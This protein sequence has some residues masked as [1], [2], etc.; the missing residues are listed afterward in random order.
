MGSRKQ[1]V[2]KIPYD[3]LLDGNAQSGYVFVT[4]DEKVARKVPVVVGSIEKNDVVIQAGLENA[5]S[6]IISGS[7][8]LKDSSAISIIK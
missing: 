4:D 6:L 3:A 2:W 1:N 7:A 5:H 8:Y